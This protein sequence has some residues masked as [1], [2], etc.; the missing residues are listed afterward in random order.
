MGPHRLRIVTMNVSH[1]FGEPCQS[2]V[3]DGTVH[4]RGCASRPNGFTLI[5]LLVVISIV[6]LLIALLLPAL[7]RA[8][9]AALLT[10][11]QANVRQITQGVLSYA[12]DFDGLLPE[13]RR[14]SSVVTMWQLDALDAV[15][16]HVGGV[17]ESVPWVAFRNMER[18]Y[19]EAFL[20]PVRESVV[21]GGFDGN[22]NITGRSYSGLQ[23]VMP[24]VL[25][26]YG[27][28]YE[29]ASGDWRV[30]PPRRVDQVA[31]QIRPGRRF[32]GAIVSDLL[33]KNHV[34]TF[35]WYGNHVWEGGAYFTFDRAITSFKYTVNTGFLDGHVDLRDKNEIY[36]HVDRGSEFFCQ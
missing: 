1:H 10:T 34:D 5:E 9:R 19:P 20:C 30:E 36:A 28:S 18:R 13:S 6:A 29:I 14:D 22:G 27:N 32:T 26:T 25:T 7:G 15:A 4:S 8:R 21:P 3:S 12:F 33:G 31:A 35:V 24:Y 17:N 11:C 23:V 16:H 2:P